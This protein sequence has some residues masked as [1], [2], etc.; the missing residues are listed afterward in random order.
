MGEV[1]G[2]VRGRDMWNRWVGKVG[3]RGGRVK[4]AGCVCGSGWKGH[5]G[6]VGGRDMR[7]R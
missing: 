5:V 7:E 6:K 2:E 1:A 3:R 4:C